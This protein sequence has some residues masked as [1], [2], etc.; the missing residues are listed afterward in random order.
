[1][2]VHRFIVFLSLL[3]VGIALQVRSAEW[4]G[5]HVDAALVVLIIAACWISVLEEA[6]LVIVAVALMNWRPGFAPELIFFAAFPLL[7]ALL[8]PYMPWRRM[9]AILG[10][11]ML[12]IMLMYVIVGGIAVIT[13]H[14]F[15][16]KDIG[17]SA[18]FALVLSRV[19]RSIYGLKGRVARGAFY[20]L[21]R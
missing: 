2:D 7:I 21:P 5:W 12:G 4:V 8:G 14:G 18:L 11:T 20:I 16:W 6:F 13:P 15:L 17:V 1:M 9:V 10:A 19:V 3:L